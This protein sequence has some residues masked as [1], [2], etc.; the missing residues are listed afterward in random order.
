MLQRLIF[1]ICVLYKLGGVYLDIDTLCLQPLINLI[2]EDDTFIIPEDKLLKDSLFQ[3][4][5]MSTPN[6]PILK[7]TINNI[8]FNIVNI[9]YKTELLKLSG[10]T[11]IGRV[12]KKY[13]NK[14]TNYEFTEGIIR[15]KNQKIKILMHYMPYTQ[16]LIKYKNKSYL[17]CQIKFNRDKSDMKSWTLTTIIY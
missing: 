11:C 3:A 8:I 6:N 16:E 10:P 5:I 12:L 14:P 17:K 4:I 15:T 7:Q 9:L 1:S 2:E 13:I